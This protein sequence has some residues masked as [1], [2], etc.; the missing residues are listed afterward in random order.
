MAVRGQK[1][2]GGRGEK[3]TRSGSAGD[4]LKSQDVRNKKA[5]CIGLVSVP[6]RQYPLT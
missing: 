3:G 5:D 6:L 2:V 1:K 4:L